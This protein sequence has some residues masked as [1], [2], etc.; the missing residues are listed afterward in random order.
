MFNETLCQNEEGEQLKKNGE[1]CA[2][3]RTEGIENLELNIL[4]L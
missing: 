1:I 3:D 4:K 2:C